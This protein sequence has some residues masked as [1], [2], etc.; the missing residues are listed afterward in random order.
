[1]VNLSTG[2]VTDKVDMYSP[3]GGSA[4][5]TS[6]GYHSAVD[7]EVDETGNVYV[8]HYYSWA[9]EKWAG[10]PSTGVDIVHSGSQLPRESVLVQN[11]P[12]PFNASTEIR[13]ALPRD[14][15]VK[16]DV[17]NVSGQRVAGLVDTD[18]PAGQYQLDWN[19]GAL[20]S[21]IYFVRLQAGG[22]N[23]VSKMALVR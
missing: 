9:I 8:V 18:Q 4:S 12:N 11:Y 23:A 15:R 10:S 16:L 3:N 2:A 1:V 22:E 19:A 13:Y 7:I 14:A 17:F 20:P 5:E 21:G 6:A